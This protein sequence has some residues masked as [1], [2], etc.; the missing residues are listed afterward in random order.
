MKAYLFDLDG[1]LSDS[2]AG[3]YPAFRAGL[4]AIGVASVSDEQLAGFL[5]TP[6]PEM[7]RGFRA[8]ITQ[9]EIDAG[10]AAFR[11]AYEITG[12]IDNEL[13]PGVIQMLTAIRQRGSAIWVVTSKPE[14]Q[15]VRIVA[16]LKLDSYVAGVIGASLAET[17]TKTDLVARALTAARVAKHEA[18]MVGDRHYDIT[19]ALANGVLPVGALWG[20]GSKQEMSAAGCG[21]FVHSPDE[22]RMRFV[23]DEIRASD[24]ASADKTPVRPRRVVR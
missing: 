6:L 3:L 23:E 10:M 9:G 7:F 16:H 19:G 4:H 12:I 18:V 17:D 14:P 20:Y 5:G 13:Y 11:A 21:E 22:F 1:T 24:G 8:G 2:R 15:A